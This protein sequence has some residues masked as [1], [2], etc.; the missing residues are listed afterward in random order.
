MEPVKAL[1][2]LE[3]GSLFEGEGFGAVGEVG[4]E[5]VFNTSMT[6]YQ[7]ILTDPSYSGQLVAMTYTEIGN[8]GVN[9]ADAEAE[10]PHVRGF[11]A[12]EFSRRASSH[13]AETSLAEYMTR[14]AIVGIHRIDTRALTRLLRDKGSQRGVIA[15]GPGLD[16]ARDRDR[17]V[18]AARAVPDLSAIDTVLGVTTARR[19]E[20]RGGPEA[21]AAAA[22]GIAR[23]TAGPTI[24][25]LDYGVKRNI[26]RSLAA[27]G[28]RVIVLP[29]KTTAD[30]VLDLDPD[31]VFLS[32]GPGDPRMA[33]YAIETIRGLMGKRPLF[34]IC[35]G[36][37]LTALASGAETFKLKFG[38]HGGNHPVLH[39]ATGK[40]EITTQNH[41][42]AVEPESARRAGYEI[43]HWN[44]Y[45]G[46]VEGMR[47]R[48]LPL[49]SV[50]YHPEAAPGPHDSQ[51]LWGE[52][53]A[54]LGV[55]DR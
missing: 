6:G 33:T 24:A 21:G 44:L 55:R 14:H 31:G 48:E 28:A 51:Y 45:D 54:L 46:T 12:R 3:D 49:F 34:G 40:I 23:A 15:S 18:A 1:L 20:W 39:E 52:F 37:Q 16:A 47:H 27:T 32:N 35:L 8:Y 2:A 13:R 10:K 9:A 41:N 22:P 4:G 19:Y 42:Y 36:H 25:A 11:I 26:L 38:H 5:V 30:E 7:E 50:Q 29:A 43:T 17:L 53:L